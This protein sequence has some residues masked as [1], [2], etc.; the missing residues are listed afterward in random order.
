MSEDYRN[1]YDYRNAPHGEGPFAG[2]W[3]DKPHR[4][5]WDVC[6][7]MEEMQPIQPT[8]LIHKA[9]HGD[10]HVIILSKAHESFAWSRLFEIL[11]AE[12]YYVPEHWDDEEM[13]A[14]YK[15]VK[16]H[17]QGKDAKYFL[18]WRSDH[19]Y[20]YEHIEIEY[21]ST[22]EMLSDELERKKA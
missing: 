22:H 10:R 4:L 13:V 1:V 14:L 20:E 17:G 16:S 2:H 6:D 15:Q 9:K 8:L 11:D 21:P 18:Q 7:I 12:G 3:N 5:F 19:G